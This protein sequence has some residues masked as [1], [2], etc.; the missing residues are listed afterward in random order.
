M[1]IEHGEFASNSNINRIRISPNCVELKGH[2]LT[3][4]TSRDAVFLV[5]LSAKRFDPRGLLQ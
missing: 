3:L 2:L 5:L 4:G 1:F